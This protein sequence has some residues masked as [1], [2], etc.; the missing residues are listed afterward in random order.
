MAFDAQLF[1]LSNFILSRI[2]HPASDVSA[3]SLSVGH[4][5]LVAH[6]QSIITTNFEFLQNL[7]EMR[8]SFTGRYEQQ[9]GFTS[10]KQSMS[11][12]GK[13]AR[14]CFVRSLSFR[15][16]KSSPGAL[17]N[18]KNSYQ[19]NYLHSAFFRTCVKT[20]NR[21]V[22]RHEIWHHCPSACCMSVTYTAS[23]LCFKCMYTL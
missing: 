12:L 20:E 14:C 1:Q 5:S 19:M 3:S 16:D 9:Y 8:S 23:V 13:R 10:Q 22:C 11:L 15:I 17:W 4:V 21:V 7:Y 18:E 6:L 2:R